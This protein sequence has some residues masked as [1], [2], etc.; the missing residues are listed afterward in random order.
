MAQKVKQSATGGPR[1]P[2]HHCVLLKTGD[3]IMW[4]C[5]VSS[6]IFKVE[7]DITDEKVKVDKFGKAMKTYVIT[8]PEGG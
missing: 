6:A 4:Q 2:N 5:P 8:A 7:V 1:C 3:H